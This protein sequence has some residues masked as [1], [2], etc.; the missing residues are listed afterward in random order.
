MT[1]LYE[2]LMLSCKKSAET[3]IMNNITSDPSEALL[4]NKY[5]NTLIERFCNF[6]V[7]SESESSSFYPSDL[8]VLTHRHQQVNM[9]ALPSDYGLPICHNKY[10]LKIFD[11]QLLF[12]DILNKKYLNFS[13]GKVV[14]FSTQIY[15]IESE[16]DECNLDE[17]YR[18]I[19]VKQYVESLIQL[20]KAEHEYTKKQTKYPDDKEK[21]Y[22]EHCAHLHC[23]K[24]EP[25]EKVKMLFAE[26]FEKGYYALNM[27]L[28]RT[29][30]PHIKK[31]NILPESTRPTIVRVMPGWYILREKITT[32]TLKRIKHF[33]YTLYPPDFMKKKMKSFVAQRI[34]PIK[35]AQLQNLRLKDYIEKVLT[36]VI[37]E[38]KKDIC[39]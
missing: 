20:R 25:D 19:K 39:E 16:D 12:W 4:T 32:E 22:N 21:E 9:N 29:F 36:S 5:I 15:E 6:L 30:M 31:N 3:F 27:K 17:S 10:I 14:H 23:I 8:F 28:L 11:S 1:A 37:E 2:A 13:L 33:L 34:H 18:K 38:N 35:D 26:L 7:I 24:A